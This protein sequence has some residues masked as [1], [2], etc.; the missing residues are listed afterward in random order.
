MVV[1]HQP[2]LADLRDEPEHVVLEKSDRVGDVPDE[3]K[4]V[5]LLR[6]ETAASSRASTRPS[7]SYSSGSSRGA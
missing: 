5:D 7:L 4:D 6:G 1:V 3:R 2:G